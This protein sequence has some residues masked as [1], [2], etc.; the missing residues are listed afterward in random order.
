MWLTHPPSLQRQPLK[1]ADDLGRALRTGQAQP[2]VSTGDVKEAASDAKFPFEVIAP[3]LPP[4]HKF[5]LQSLVQELTR[6]K[7]EKQHR[8]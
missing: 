6:H 5:G 4:A 2:L 8:T 3:W 7:G 1:T